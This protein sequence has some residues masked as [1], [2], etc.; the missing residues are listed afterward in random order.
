MSVTQGPLPAQ[1]ST[2]TDDHLGEGAFERSGRKEEEVETYDEETALPCVRQNR[3]GRCGKG[4]YR[5]DWKDRAFF[6]SSTSDPV[7]P[8]NDDEWDD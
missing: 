3:V 6:H 2:G 8:R 7:G 4:P 1:V 5:R